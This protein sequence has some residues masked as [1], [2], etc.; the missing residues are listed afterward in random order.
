MDLKNLDHIQPGNTHFEH[1]NIHRKSSNDLDEKLSNIPQKILENSTTPHG[2][3]PTLVGQ[4][5]ERFTL[6]RQLFYKGSDSESD[7]DTTNESLSL[8]E[9]NKS[10]EDHEYSVDGCDDNENQNFLSPNYLYSNE[11]ILHPIIE[12]RGMDIHSRKLEGGPDTIKLTHEVSFISFDELIE[13]ETDSERFEA[14]L[15]KYGLTPSDLEKMNHLSQVEQESVMEAIGASVNELPNFALLSPEELNEVIKLVR[16]KKKGMNL[17]RGIG[18]KFIDPTITAEHR[19]KELMT[20]VNEMRENFADSIL[21]IAEKIVHQLEETHQALEGAQLFVPAAIIP[22][23]LIFIAL[24]AQKLR[25]ARNHQSSAREIKKEILKSGKVTKNL[26]D[27]STNFKDCYEKARKSSGSPFLILLAKS[28]DY[29]DGKLD[30]RAKKIGVTITGGLTE[31]G[32]ALTMAATGPSGY[33]PAAGLITAALGFGIQGTVPAHR[34]A[35]WIYKYFSGT[36]GVNREEHARFI[37]GLALHALEKKQKGAFFNLPEAE[38]SLEFIETLNPHKG[39]M[40]WN[41]HYHLHQKDFEEASKL[42][43]KFLIDCDVLTLPS[44][45]DPN[46]IIKVEEFCTV[47]F[48]KIMKLFKST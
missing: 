45:D 6:K 13:E 2:E 15:A 47:G 20:N 17:E 8:G 5:K 35:K 14:M 12:E 38:R 7:D 21:F 10:L 19:R 16:E 27:F 24:D 48:D 31:M 11:N 43:L 9:S 41:S 32:G 39:I 30:A 37:Y 26:E 25:M 42:A 1:H 40:G 28:M 22:V 36:L 33:G 34:I 3:I 29:V 4:N 23:L 46:Y 44:P 18:V